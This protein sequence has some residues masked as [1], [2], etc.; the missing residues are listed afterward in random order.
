MNTLTLLIKKTRK[1]KWILWV[2]SNPLISS[3]LPS[4]FFTPQILSLQFFDRAIYIPRWIPINSKDTVEWKFSFDCQILG[5][6]KLRVVVVSC[7]LRL[8]LL[9]TRN[10]VKGILYFNII[11]IL[12]LVGS[13]LEA[14]LVF[15]QIWTPSDQRS[16]PTE[17]SHLPNK[18]LIGNM[19]FSGVFWPLPSWE[20]EGPFIT[21]NLTDPSGILGDWV[22]DVANAQD[23]EHWHN[24]R[25]GSS[26]EARRCVV[27]SSPRPGGQRRC[28]RG[29]R[30]RYTC[31]FTYNHM[32]L[33]NKEN[34]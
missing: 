16:P 33:I 32:Y 15:C 18:D 8:L 3:S 2:E 9:V 25:W 12:F 17:E 22:E 31:T 1:Q 5:R 10:L 13:D 34:E 20:L 19:L 30:R 6:D 28:R 23:S 21:R 27:I 29:D 11:L 7:F 24:G 26:V 4:T 14:N